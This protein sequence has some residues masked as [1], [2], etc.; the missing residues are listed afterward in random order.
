MSTS[1]VGLTRQNGAS[2]IG[3]HRAHPSLIDDLAAE[4]GDH[5]P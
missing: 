3:E 4:C 2:E 1:S 5:D